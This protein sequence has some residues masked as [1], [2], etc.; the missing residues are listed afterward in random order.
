MPNLALCFVYT[1]IIA[2]MNIVPIFVC[3]LIIDRYG[4]TC[5]CMYTYMTI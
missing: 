5:T 3:H 4:Y 2:T 1:L